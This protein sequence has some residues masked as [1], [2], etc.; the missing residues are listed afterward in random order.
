MVQTKEKRRALRHTGRDIARNVFRH[1]NAVL[2]IIL[3]AIIGVMAVLTRGLTF[4]RSNMLNTL[5]NSSERGVVSVG[6][7][8]VILTAGIDLS[9]GG[10]AILSLCLG[11]MGMVGGGQEV[12]AG[13]VIS[14]WGLPIAVAILM[15]LAIGAG[16][17]AVN[18]SF[19]SRLGVP[20]LIVTLAMWEIFRGVSY[21]L[22]RGFTIS[23][24]P[25]SFAFFGQG[26]VAGVPVPVIIFIVVGVICYFV[27]YHTIFGRSV[28]AVGGNPT[29]AWLSGLRV[30]NTLLMVYV[31]SG[32]LS[33]LAGIIILGRMMSASI[34]ALVGLELD[35]I[36]AVCIGGISLAG[37]RG[38]LIGAIIGAIIIGVVNN[39]MN[40]IGVHPAFQTIVKGIIILVAVTIDTI[41]RR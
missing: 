5:L 38:T 9:V 19:V 27:L 32:F 14:G 36:A 6:Q 17:G 40:V 35:S 39:G 18:G 33:A 2:V 11:A 28:Y 8:F 24:L 31:I 22:T 34:N 23:G 30:K 41:R 29:S 3:V 20:P 16:F 12:A 25:R 4:T 10:L 1:E 26:H 13:H 21:N 37:G 15:M 7:A